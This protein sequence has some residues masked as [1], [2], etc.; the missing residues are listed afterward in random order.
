MN[1]YRAGTVSY[2]QVADPT[3]RAPYQ[4]TG[5]ARG[6]RAA[7]VAAVQLVRALGGGW[8]ADLC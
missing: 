3:D 5:Y 4:S 1:Q 8:K 7:F 2:L 6:G